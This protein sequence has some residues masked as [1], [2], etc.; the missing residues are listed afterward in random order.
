MGGGNGGGPPQTNGSGGGIPMVNG[1]PS[2]GQQTDMNYLWSVVQQL[3]Q[4]LEENRAQTVGIVNGVQAIQQRAAEEGGVVGGVGM[5]EVNGELNAATR[6]AELSNLQ[7]QLS[8]AQTTISSLTSSNTQL[9]SL[10][11]D[12]ENALTLLL[13]KLRPYAYTQTQA[14]LSLHK[15]YQGLLD[16]ERNTSMQLRLEHAE[17]Q[18]GLGRV[19]EYARGA[20]KGHAESE[21]GLLREVK[22]LKEENRVLRRLVGWEE[23]EEEDSSDEEE[24]DR[25]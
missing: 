10:L 18:A 15:H 11:T 7:S 12:Y 25:P 6:A 19:A 13:E 22:E 4:V 23:K 1:L 16:T 9:T 20:L 14:I 3:S 17:W 24:A 21:M 8:S 5:R 2:G